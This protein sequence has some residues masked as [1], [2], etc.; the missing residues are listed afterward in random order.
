VEIGKAPGNRWKYFVGAA[1]LAVGLLVKAGAPVAP[2][3]LGLAVAAFFSWRKSR[4]S[5]SPR[6]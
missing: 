2:L 3:A 6:R 4:S 5:V 1:I